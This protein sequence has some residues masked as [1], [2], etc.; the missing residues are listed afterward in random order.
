MG[1]VKKAKQGANKVYTQS[2]RGN[3][4]E[5]CMELK[6]EVIRIKKDKMRLDQN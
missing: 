2:M 6:T 1:L 4:P 5:V 3:H